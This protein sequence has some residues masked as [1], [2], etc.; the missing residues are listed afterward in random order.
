MLSHDLAPL[1]HDKISQLEEKTNI[2]RDAEQQN[3]HTLETGSET[4]PFVESFQYQCLQW[5]CSVTFRKTLNLFKLIL[6][7]SRSCSL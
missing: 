5:N 7:S 4:M 1:K 3:L 2:L 6:T